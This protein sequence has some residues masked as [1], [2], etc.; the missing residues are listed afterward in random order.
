MRRRNP[1]KRK[2]LKVE[3]AYGQLLKGWSTLVDVESAARLKPGEGRLWLD[4][5]RA[6]LVPAERIE[7]REVE[8]FHD[9]D[10]RIRQYRVVRQEALRLAPARRRVERQPGASV[11]EPQLALF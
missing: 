11:G 1:L 2:V 3:R 9:A 6:I 4:A 8:D 10:V 5:V 7:E